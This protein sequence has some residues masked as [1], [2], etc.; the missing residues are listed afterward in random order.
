LNGGGGGSGRRKKR[1]VEL[2]CKCHFLRRALKEKKKRNRNSW[3]LPGISVADS[4]GKGHGLQND[5]AGGKKGSGRYTI[6]LLTPRKKKE[7]HEV[8]WPSFGSR[9]VGGKGEIGLK[10]R[11]GGGGPE[12]GVFPRLSARHSKIEETVLCV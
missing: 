4:R 1:G 10:G 9:P 3:I 8:I 2:D 12:E 7:E 5:A 6:P 11:G